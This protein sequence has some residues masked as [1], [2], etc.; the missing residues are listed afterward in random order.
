MTST[1]YFPAGSMGRPSGP[2]VQSVQ[3][4]A[5]GTP[6]VGLIP[7][8]LGNLYMPSYGAGWIWSSIDQPS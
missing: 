6:V 2:V 7:V 3:L 8:T 4:V 5:D 1:T